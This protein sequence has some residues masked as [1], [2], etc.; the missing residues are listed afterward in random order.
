MLPAAALSGTFVLYPMLDLVRVA[1][2]DARTQGLAYRY[3]ADTFRA[4]VGSSEFALMAG[5][6]LVFVFASV[7][8]QMTT[9][10]GVAVL[11]DAARRRGAFGTV[12]ARAAVLLGWIIPGVLVGVLWRLLLVE[13]RSGI[14]N[15]ALSAFGAGPL[16]LLSTPALALTAVIVANTWRGAAFT[17]IL[18]YAGL[19]RIPRELH[20]A[21]D[22][23]GLGAWARLRWLILPQLAP[24]L[25]L[26]L[27]LATIQTLNTFDLI[28]PLTGGG[29][30]RRTEVVS[31]FMYRS[32]F[33]ELEAGRAAAVAVLLLAVNLALAVVALR[34]GERWQEAPR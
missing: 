33:F 21:A 22:L 26:N 11:V 34:L 17:M 18:Q 19:Q 15:H 32:A 23:E 20:E 1:F 16:P 8:L 30:A 31:L 10:L 13:N 27:V 14:V 5:I 24:V 4:L 6:T 3:T 29:P 28:L 2:T 12:P 7:A 9:G 25:A